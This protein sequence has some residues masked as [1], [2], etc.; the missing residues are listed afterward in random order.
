M[1]KTAVAVVGAL[2]AVIGIGAV[3]GHT[4]STSSTTKP[5]PGGGTT[6]PPPPP[7]GG[8]SPPGGKTGTAWIRASQ[9]NPGDH[10]RVSVA[11]GDLGVIAAGLGI[12]WPPADPTAAATALS[13]VLANPAVHTVLAPAGDN[14]TAWIPGQGLPGD[15]PADDVNAATEYHV[16]FS[17]AGAAPVL[18]SSLPIP[19]QVWAAKGLGLGA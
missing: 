10:V 17:Y 6:P 2:A 1:W 7:G 9:I 19:A 14:F 8:T 18:V 13:A 16:E 15:W 5:A 11:S 12:A 3:V 4:K